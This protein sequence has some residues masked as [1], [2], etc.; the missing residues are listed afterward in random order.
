MFTAEYNQPKCTLLADLHTYI[1]LSETMRDDEESGRCCVSDQE[2]RAIKLL[3]V[4]SQLLLNVRI[5]FLDEENQR[6]DINS[7]ESTSFSFIE[8]QLLSE[9]KTTINNSQLNARMQLAACSEEERNGRRSA[10]S[11]F[12]SEQ[13]LI[14]H[15]QTSEQVVIALWTGCDLFYLQAAWSAYECTRN[16]I[17]IDEDET[18]SKLSSYLKRDMQLLITTY[19]LESTLFSRTVVVQSEQIS[20]MQVG[21]EFDCDVVFIIQMHRLALAEHDLRIQINENYSVCNLN[22]QEAYE[23]SRYSIS[24]WKRVFNSLEDQ[25][26]SER[27]CV[28]ESCFLLI[29][30]IAANEESCHRIAISELEWDRYRNQLHQ[31]NQILKLLHSETVDRNQLLAEYEYNHPCQVCFYSPLSLSLFYIL[32]THF[33]ELNLNR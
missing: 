15:C 3:I 16:L 17:S 9:T 31:Y 26:R 6:R 22:C 32:F 8:T 24:C 10:I 21:Q 12:F 14:T 4:L 33:N 7:S 20:R 28:V 13:D 11:Q 5:I 23:S 25:E 19:C 27:K 2:N 29:V 30:V 18:R 1:Y